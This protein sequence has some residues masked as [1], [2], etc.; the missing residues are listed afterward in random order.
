MGH[1]DRRQ[2]L[3]GGT[4]GVLGIAA[5]AM[6]PT[7][8]F[9]D[10]GEG[11]VGTWDLQITDASAPGGPTTFEGAT[12]FNPGGGVVNVDSQS[13]ST[14]LG[15]WSEG[16]DGS[17]KARFMQFGF[18]SFNVPDPTT[19]KLVVTINGKKSGNAISGSFTYKVYTLNGAVVFPNGMGTFTGTRFA[20]T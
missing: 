14:G 16:D 20:A 18:N 13:P 7:T 9:A 10:E 17:F 11:I 19:V 4:A 8:A 15:S 12:T 2:L 5:A 6:G 3:I 1:L